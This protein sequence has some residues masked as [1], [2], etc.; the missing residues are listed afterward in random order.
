MLA[1]AC[2][3]RASGSWLCPVWI[4]TGSGRIRSGARVYG[5]GPVRSGSGVD[6]EWVRSGSGVGTEWD[7]IGSGLIGLVPVRAGC[8]LVWTGLAPPKLSVRFR[9][10][11]IYNLK[12]GSDCGQMDEQARGPWS[13][14]APTN[15]IRIENRSAPATV[16]G[17]GPVLA[18]DYRLNLV[19]VCPVLHPRRPLVCG[20][21]Y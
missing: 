17:N 10:A 15:K 20:H 18:P 19:P 3:L 11:K 13:V 8:D 14:H 16:P 12:I 1:L 2:T 21:Y 5:S 4:L 6:S 7:W 9:S